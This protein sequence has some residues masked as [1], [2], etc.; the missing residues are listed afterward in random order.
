MDQLNLKTSEKLIRD[1]H[2]L[3][4]YN[5]ISTIED[6]IHT[7]YKK[8][9]YIAKMYIRNSEYGT[10][11]YHYK[12]DE[13]CCEVANCNNKNNMYMSINPMKFI[14]GESGKWTIARDKKH[15]SKLNWLY[16]DL[17]TYKTDYTN[18]QIYMC[19]KDE[20]F[21][22]SIPHP[23]MVIDSGR[24][25]YL[26]WHIDEHIL[27]YNRW[28]K[29]QKYFYNVLKDFGADGA[30][31]T[32]TARVLRCI[33]SI[34]P[35]SGRVVSV[36]ESRAYKYT[37]YDI[38]QE[39]MPIEKSYRNNKKKIKNSSSQSKVSFLWYEVI[40]KRLN[41]L[42]T[43]LI[44]YRDYVGSGR[45]NILFLY[46]YWQCYITGDP[47]E[48]LH[49][50]IN[51]NAKIKFKLSKEELI[52]ATKSAEKAFKDNCKYK[53]KTNS[54]IDFLNITVEEMKGLKSLVSDAI[55]IERKR[56][57]S[58][59][60]Y[61]GNLY[62][63]GKIEKKEEVKSRQEL[64][65]SYIEEGKSVKEICK[66]LKISR[67]TYYRD[68]KCIPQ[69]TAQKNKAKT[70]ELEMQ[71]LNGFVNNPI[72]TERKKDKSKYKRNLY[73]NRKI[74]K[75]ELSILKQIF[76]SINLL[77]TTSVSKIL[78]CIIEYVVL[79]SLWLLSG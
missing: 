7:Y 55:K 5:N 48:A 2:I 61:K 25:M 69:K 77:P 14:K 35:K 17:D 47:E 59:L 51:L 74:E 28:L 36:I 50:T 22:S 31:V 26:L 52:R 24:G 73:T 63:N 4:H 29:V 41:D 66:M 16:V 60:K 30:V 70:N 21:G 33:G 23:T 65:K 27:A 54:V 42:E 64:I 11:T 43:L 49:R 67:A 32:D 13:F 8:N 18:N 78:P 9:D 1:L 72:K 20:Y 3:N 79:I 10:Y 76:N 71:D 40:K 44:N 39:Y 45:E 53:Y 58:K 37:L 68:M 46:R 15:V 57:K 12:I 19:L 62:I 6:F 38:I 34:N 56:E 75:K